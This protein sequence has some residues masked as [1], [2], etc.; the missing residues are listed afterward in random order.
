MKSIMEIQF[1]KVL[2]PTF[3]KKDSRGKS[4]PANVYGLLNKEMFHISEL[5]KV[6]RCFE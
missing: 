4:Y 5:K 3:E 2:A 6:K 1:I